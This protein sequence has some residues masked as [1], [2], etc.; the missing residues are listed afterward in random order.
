MEW[1]FLLKGREGKVLQR[2][3]GERMGPA[4]PRFGRDGCRTRT[5]MRV[6]KDAARVGTMAAKGAAHVASKNAPGVQA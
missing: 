6:P 3:R 5:G 2:D 4:L 1:E